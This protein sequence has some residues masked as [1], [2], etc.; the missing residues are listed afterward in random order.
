M[1]EHF[2]RYSLRWRCPIK[3]V[4]LEEGQMK[5]GNVTVVELGEGQFSFI[6][7]RKKKTPTTLPFD[8]IMAAGY[9][10]GDDGDTSKKTRETE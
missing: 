10:R 4:W 5:S 1:N 2:L 6:T 9:A 7:A 3:L 8:V